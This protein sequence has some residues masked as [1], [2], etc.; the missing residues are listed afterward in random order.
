M[1]RSRVLDGAVED[2]AVGHVAEAGRDDALAPSDREGEVAAGADDPHLARRV[3]AL[4]HAAH[5]R[6][7]G[8]PVEQAG[9][10]DE[11]LE[12]GQR[13]ARLLD[14]RGVGNWT[15]AQRTSSARERRIAGSA[16]RMTACRTSS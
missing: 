14:A 5:A 1:T 4:L 16:A 13:H 15:T 2:L 12:L 9:A 8:L 3:E 11:V 7:L 6:L 10:V